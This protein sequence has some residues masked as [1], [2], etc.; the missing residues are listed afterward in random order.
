M[1]RMR[2]PRSQVIVF[3]DGRAN[4]SLKPSSSL[5]R[6]AVI[7]DELKELGN[8]FRKLAATV[9]VANTQRKFEMTDDPKRLAQLVEAQLI[10]VSET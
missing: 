10:N 4:V 9:V 7:A 6:N 2:L 3:T 8:R 1:P 5:D